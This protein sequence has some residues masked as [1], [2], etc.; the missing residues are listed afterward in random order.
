MGRSDIYKDAKGFDKNPQNINRNGRP[1]KSFSTIN[2]DLK[3]QGVE[4]LKKAQLIEAYT[5]VFNSTKEELKEISENP[6][7]PIGLNIIITQLSNKDTKDKAMNDY[8]DYMFGKAVQKTEIKAEVNHTNM[9]D[10][11]LDAEIK[12]FDKE[13]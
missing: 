11:E 3:K 9:T 2:A 1:R 4:P 6:D 10:D 13:G 8:R 12:R 7:T 5:L